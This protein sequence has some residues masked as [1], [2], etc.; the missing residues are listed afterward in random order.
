MASMKEKGVTTVELLIALCLLGTAFLGL[1]AAFPYAMY[2]VTAGGYQT[3]ATLLAQQSIDRAQNTAWSGLCALEDSESAP[4]TDHSAYTRTLAISPACGG[5]PE[6]PGSGS[7]T[8]AT[9][10]VTVVFSGVVPSP[11]YQTTLVTQIID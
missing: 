1:A 5:S 3:S 4:I 6:T 8:L 10:T 9:V 7:A 11:I 2:G